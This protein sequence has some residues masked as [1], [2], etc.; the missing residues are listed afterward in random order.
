M[1][2]GPLRMRALPG[3]VSA[4]TGKVERV[5]RGRMSRRRSIALTAASVVIAVAVATAGAASSS[6]GRTSSSVGAH[7]A[8]SGIKAAAPPGSIHKIK[9]V[10]V[11]MQENRSFDSYFGTYPGADGYPTVDGRFSVCVPNPATG[12]CDYPYHDPALVNMGAKHNGPAAT[13]DIAGGTMTGFIAEAQRTTG[14]TQTDVMGYHDAREI[15][16]YWTYAHDFVLQD[17]MFEPNASWSLPAHLFTVSEWS[18]A[19]STPNP[20]SCVNDD[21]QGNL[22]QRWG[23]TPYSDLAGLIYPHLNQRDA[24]VDRAVRRRE[25]RQPWPPPLPHITD[26]AWTDMTYLLHKYHVSWAYYV[27]PGT[28]PDCADD[29]ATCKAMPTQGPHT[30]GIWNPLPNFETVRVDQQEANIQSTSSFYDAVRKGTLPSVS[31]IVPNLADS[32][33]APAPVTDGMTYVTGLIDAIMRSPDWNSTAIFLT[34]DDWGG[35]YDNVAPPD[36]D[37]NGYGL[38]VPALVI[39]PYARRGYIDHQTLSFDAYNKFIEDDFLHGQ[40]LDPSTDGRPD[41]RPTVRDNVP[42]LGNLLS[43]FDFQQA[44]RKPILLPLHPSPGPASRP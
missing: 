32:E 21:N 15:P 35:F 13:A 11:I 14:H 18:A 23:G 6:G 30:P 43:D 17:H 34:W 39:S 44:P 3:A 16:N 38:R 8:Y 41:P 36:V 37:E 12:G 26:L 27:T 40:R 10:V 29:D 31:W 33:H 4:R 20:A 28:E 24:A 42:I 7:A 2:T 5:H 25:E 1:R 19:C 9:H 22:G